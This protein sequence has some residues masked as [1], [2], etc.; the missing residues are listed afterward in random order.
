MPKKV[1]NFYITTEDKDFLKK[2]F[3]NLRFSALI[4][5][6]DIVASL[7]EEYDTMSLYSRFIV[8]KTI[9]SQ[10]ENVLKRK[11]FFNIIYHNP[12]IDYDS[13][14]NLHEQFHDNASIKRII[15][16]DKKDNPTNE[17]LWQ[18]FEEVTF[19]PSVKKKKIL[20]CESFKT[21]MFYWL[22]DI[23]MPEDMKEKYPEVSKTFLGDDNE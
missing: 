21:P 10:V 18:Y 22:N 5:V 7:D 13:I 19:F 3:L 12:W 2:N 15:L 9:I 20:E 16:L 8:N 1:M 23:E 17:D 14:K 4:S 6:P 11:R